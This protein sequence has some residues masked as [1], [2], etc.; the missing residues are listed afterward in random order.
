[1]LTRRVNGVFKP[2]GVD[3]G[4]SGTIEIISSDEHY[5]VLKEKDKKIEAKDKEIK[6]LKAL[7]TP[8]VTETR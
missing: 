6:A 7:K 2:V 1:M 5:K 3:Q 4:E 8:S